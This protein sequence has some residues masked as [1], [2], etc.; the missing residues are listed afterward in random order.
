MTEIRRIGSS[1]D[2]LGEGPI[3]CPE[4]Q[5]LYWV[6]IRAPCIHRWEQAG[7]ST[8]SWTM[9]DAIGSFALASD[10]RIL[11]AL[12]DR[13]SLFD[14][15]TGGF[16]L[17][18]MLRQDGDG[19]RS[20]DGKCDRQG[21]FWMGSMDESQRAQRGSL[22]RLAGRDL[23][24]VLGGL[25]VPNSLCFAPDGRTMYFTDT[26]SKTIWAFPY[27]PASGEL[28]ARRVFVQTDAS[29]SPDGATVD[30]EGYLW[31]AR[32]HGGRVVR[33]A[34]DGSVDRVVEVAARQVTCCAFGGP[35]L[36]TLFITTATQNLSPEQLAAQ[37]AAG[38]LLAL[39][40]G[41]KGLA[42]R[43]FVV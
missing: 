43:R 23:T 1:I 35:G 2:A 13:I 8:T 30:A 41:V 27:D 28:G 17:V 22:Y 12:R 39:E 40:V 31:S 21:R 19:I 34:P 7:D 11:A 20:N 38:H 6:D 36:T 29:E 37:P 16:E 10:G 25:D 42:E 26:P 24:A 32:Y 3:W 4:A 33:H 5:A 15:A 9:P 14:P 18:A